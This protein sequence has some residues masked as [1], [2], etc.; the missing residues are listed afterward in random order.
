MDE[1]VILTPASPTPL[2]PRLLP[3][4]SCQ[5]AESRLQTRKIVSDGAPT[6][7]KVSC[8]HLHFCII[9]GRLSLLVCPY[10]LLRAWFFIGNPRPE[11]TT[12][13]LWKTTY[14]IRAGPVTWRL[15]YSRA[16]AAGHAHQNCACVERSLGIFLK[17][18]TH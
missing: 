6:E 14:R 1:R 8:Q 2:L 9:L 11:I 15:S 17:V 18:L 4:P 5:G 16:L 13:M 10:R 12:S 7:A 3:W